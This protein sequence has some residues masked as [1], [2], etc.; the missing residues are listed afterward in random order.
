MES[1]VPALFLLIDESTPEFSLISY[2]FVYIA[3]T[4]MLKYFQQV[5]IYG[6]KGQACGEFNSY[7][8]GQHYEDLR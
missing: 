3:F 6:R 7:P 2:V 5:R 8:N 1:G 4:V